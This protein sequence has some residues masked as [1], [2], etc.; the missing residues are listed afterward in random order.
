MNNSGNEKDYRL[1]LWAK[2]YKIYLNK[3][4]AKLLV[5]T[6]TQRVYTITTPGQSKVVKIM[7]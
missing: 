4:K 2:F 7:H 1:N 6:I 3:K 5:K